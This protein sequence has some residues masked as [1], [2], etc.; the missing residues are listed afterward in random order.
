[1]TTITSR[2]AK[3]EKRRRRK[4]AA[5]AVAKPEFKVAPPGLAGG[6][7]RPLTA[8]QVERIYQ[9]ALVVLEETGIE[10]MPSPCREVWRRAGARIDADRNR[11]F[12]PP[13]LI[14]AAVATAAREVRLCGQ[15]SEH[16][17]TLGGCACAHGN[18]GRR[19]QR[20]GA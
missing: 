16:D 9:A 20:F 3:P 8:E 14:T 1:M 4:R 12:I 5:A 17:L 15:D 18:R 11:V 2:P 6:R 7:Y 10:V 19:Y 13:S